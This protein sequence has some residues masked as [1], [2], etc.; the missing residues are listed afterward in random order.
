VDEV[1]VNIQAL[2]GKCTL[3]YFKQFFKFFPD[4][5]KTKNRHK[6][7]AQDPLNNLM[8][9]GYEVL[10]RRVHIAVAATHLNP[11]IGYL[12][13]IQ[14]GKPSLVCDPMEAWRFR[15]EDFILDY[16]EKLDPDCFVLHGRRSFLKPEPMYTFTQALDRHIDSTRIPYNYSNNSRTKRIRTAIKEELKKQHISSEPNTNNAN[17]H[18]QQISY[19]SSTY[20]HLCIPKLSVIFKLE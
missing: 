8:N 11:Y 15:V 6:R 13:G 19:K 18:M 9:L 16:H 12:H 7:G 5:L 14:F 2:E 1:R 10:K 20:K 3:E 4:F 17:L